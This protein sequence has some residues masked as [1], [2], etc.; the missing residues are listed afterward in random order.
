M[1]S[2]VGPG[3]YA[4][5]GSVLD[6]F[7]SEL[8][9]PVRVDFSYGAAVLYRFNL[10][11]QI[12]VRKIKSVRFVVSSA[13]VASV[14]ISDFLVGLHPLLFRS[15]VLSWGGASKNGVD[16]NTCSYESYL[17]SG[18]SFDVSLDLGSFG[19]FINK[20]LFCYY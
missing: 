1:S 15:S 19:I 17:G 6:V 7:P 13:G 9:F 2:V 4:R 3:T 16:L 12:T 14:S 11:S 20:K 5:R 10:S 18:L 8:S